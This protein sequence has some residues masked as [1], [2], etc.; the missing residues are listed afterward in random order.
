MD[1]DST[2]DD[3]RSLYPL[4]F[5]CVQDIISSLKLQP[6]V[7]SRTTNAEPTRIEPLFCRSVDLQLNALYINAETIKERGQ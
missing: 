2:K 5:Y 3:E 4:W 6:T 7:F 1:E